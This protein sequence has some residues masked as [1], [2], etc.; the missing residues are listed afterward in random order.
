MIKAL[1]NLSL[2]SITMV[3]VVVALALN[4][5]S[6]QAQYCTPPHTS[7]TPC[8]SD[9]VFATI[10]NS[11]GAACAVPSYTNY[12]T[13]A[14]TAV[15]TKGLT[16]NM[17]VV[18]T[19]ASNNKISVWIDYNQNQ[20]Y[21]ASEWTRVYDVGQSG[22]VNITIPQTALSG[23]TGMRI[24][25]RLAS[26]PNEAI[27][28]CTSF[29]G[30][31]SE[32]Y[33]VTIID[34]SPCVAPP[35]AG[36]TIASSTFICPS[37][38]FNLSM[39]GNAFGTGMTY[40]WQSSTDSLVWTDMTGFT[41][42][43]AT[44]QITSTPVF[45]RCEL[46]CNTVKSA[47]TPV[48]VRPRSLL[49]GGTYT[50]NATL[51][52][53]STNFNSFAEFNAAI[54]CGITGP[55][56]L[57]V[58]PG[59][60]VGTLSLVNL[61][62]T[63]SVNTVTINGK[64]ATLIDTLKTGKPDFI[65]QIRG[66]NYVTIDSLTIEAHSSS[67]K[68]FVVSMGNA[69]YNT[70][71]NC[72][73]RGNQTDASSTTIGGIILSGTT[74]SATTATTG[75][76]NTFENNDISGGYYGMMLYGTTT[77][78][79]MKGNVIKNNTIRDYAYYGMYLF[80]GDSTQIIRN[81]IH[82]KNRTAVATITYSI[83]SGGAAQRYLIKGNK[84]H[85]V[86]QAGSSATFY[87][88]FCT[89]N[90]A[91][92]STQ[93]IVANNA[94]YNINTTGSQYCIYNTGSDH[95]KYFYNTVL[96]DN[97]SATAGLCYGFYQLTLATGIE[98]KNNIFSISKGGSGAKYCM[99]FGT[100]TTI[101]NTNYNDLYV[102]TSV[103]GTGVKNI[104]YHSAARVTLADWQ[105]YSSSVY[106]QNS[107]NV[108]PSISGL[109]FDDVKPNAAALNDAGVALTDIVDDINGTLRSGT[110]PDIGAVEF[111]PANDDAGVFSLVSPKGVCPG[112][113]MVSVRVKNY[114]ISTLSSVNVN[115]SVN[116]VN[117]TPYSYIGLVNSGADTLLSIGTF[118]VVANTP[119]NLKIWTS[120]PNSAVDANAV[121]DTIT[122]NGLRTG[123]IG[124]VTVGGSGADFADLQALST[125]LSANGICGTTTVNVNA[126]AGPYTTGISLQNVTGLSSS[127]TLTI[128]GNGAVINTLTHGIVLNKASYVT[129]DSFNVNLNGTS[130]FGIH[131]ME[132]DYNT[133]RKNTV[134]ITQDKTASTFSAMAMSG[135]TT[136][137]L[138]AG[139]FR[140]NTIENNVFNGGYYVLTVYGNSAD[141][142]SAV[143]NVVRNNKI[144]N[145]Y[146]YSI[147]SLGT[148]SL[149]VE[150]NDINRATRTLNI[151][152]F[153]GSFF[154]TGTRNL[155]YRN[156]KIHSPFPAG[157]TGTSISY[158]MY[159]SADATVGTENI[160]YNN[161]GYNI[162][163]SG[164][165][166]GLYTAGSDGSWYH[167]NTIDIGGTGAGT[168]YAVYQTTAA[169][170]VQFINNSLNINRI[171]GTGTRILL[172]LATNT[173]TV[174]SNYNHLNGNTGVVYGQWGTTQGATLA[175]WKTI[176]SSAFDQNSIDG[177]PTFNGIK[178]VIPKVGS[179][180]V[181][182]GTPLTTVTTDLLGVT[183]NSSTPTIG[184]YENA[185]DFSGPSITFTPVLNTLST[186]NYT[187]TNF[188]NIVDLTG[189]DTTAAN[190]PRLYYKLSTNIDTYND[191][192]SATDGWKY[193]SA[194]NTSSPFSFVIDY[195][196]LNA[197]L[198]VG[199][200]VQYFVVAQDVSGAA[201]VN[202]PLQ[203][204]DDPTNVNLTAG[205]FPILG[206]SPNSYRIA[207]TI[208]GTFVVGG[209]ETFK[210]LSGTASIFEH[211]NNN[212]LSG[213]VN[214]VVKTN[215]FETGA[216]ALN[217]FAETGAGGYKITIRPNADTL[218]TLSG[219]FV[220][221]LIKLNGTDRVIIDG[222]FNGSGKYL[223]FENNSAT[224]GT[225]G[226]QIISL[227]DNAGATKI[228]I[229]NSIILAGTAGNAIPIH[230]GGLTLPYS[231]GASNNNIKIVNNTI[232]RGSV[233][234]YSG[235]VAGFESDSLL[236]E[237][238]TIGSD[239]VGEQLRLYGMALEIQKNAKVH[240]NLIKNINNTAAQQAWGIA[241]YDGFLN[242]QI[243]NNKIERV[244]SGSGAFGGRGIE[245]ISN[246][247]NDN[248]L[249]AN[250]FIG[251]MAGGG[252]SNL[253]STANVGISIVATGGVKLYYNSVSLSGTS[254]I[255]TGAIPP[256]SAAL[257][258]G[259][260]AR[261]LDIRNNSFYNTLTNISDT[262]YAYAFYSEVGD[263]AFS[264]FNYNNYYASGTQGK[265]GFLTTDL[266]SLA[267][268]VTATS[269]N[270]N[271]INFNPNY[272][273]ATD[274]HAQGVSLYQKATPIAGITTDID[275]ETRS[276]TLPCIGA[277][278][279][280]PPPSEI[281]LVDILYPKG[282]V[283]CGIAND[284]IVI[285]VQNLGTATQTS[286]NVGAIISGAVNTTLNSTKTISLAPNTKDTITISG[287][288]SSTGTG[289]LSIKAYAKVTGDGESLNDTLTT[290]TT[291][292]AI[293]ANPTLSIVSP[294]CSGGPAMVFANSPAS[295]SWFANATGGP[296]IS[297]NDTL[298]T[299]PI[300]SATT[301]YAEATTSTVQNYLGGLPAQ[302]AGTS[303]AGT[304]NFGIVFDVL[305]PVTLQKVTVYP[306]AGVAG[307]AGTVTIDV[308][309]SAN[310]VLHTATV[311]VIGNPSTAAG[312]SPQEVTLNFNLVPGTNYKIRP[313]TRSAGITGLLF[314]PSATAPGGNYG[315]P[316][317]VP[318]VISITTSTLTA[319]PTNTARND[320]YYYFY[321]WKLSEGQAGCP[322]A[323]MPIT[324]V[325]TSGPAGSGVAQS[326]PFTGVFN[327]GT[328]VNADAACVSDT[329]TYSL[330]V[331]T[332][333]NLAGLGTTWNILNPVVK[334]L[335]GATPVGAIT[336]NGLSLQ[337]VAAAGDVDS[338]LMFTARVR[339]LSTGCDTIITRYLKVFGTPSVNLGN[340]QSICDGSVLTLDAGQASTYL[341]STGATTQT[342]QVSSTGIYSVVITNAAG[343]DATDAIV[344]NTTPSPSVN[345]GADVSSC[346]GTAV[347]LDAGNTGASYLWNTGATTQTIQAS[348]SG[349]YTVT[350][351]IGNCID[352]DTIQVS[353]NALPVVSLG[354]DADICTSDTITL[355]AG[356]TGSTYLWSTGATTQTIRV[357]NAGTYSVT[358]TNANTCVN[359][360]EIV[361]TNKAVPVSTFAVT[362]STGQSVT[363]LA[364]TT[365]GLQYAWNFG[366]PTSPANT[367][368]LA[369]PTH[370]FTAPGTYT[371][372]L[373]VTNVATGC[374]ATTTET[375]VVTGLGNDFAEVFKLGAAP[376]PFAGRT[377]ISYVLPENANNVTIEVYDM[378]G[379][380]V[381]S[382]L[383]DEYQAA[384]TYT[385][386]YKNEDLQTSSGVYMVRLTVDGN[387]AYSR[388]IDIAKK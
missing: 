364:T 229:K 265:L 338:T 281:E 44:A 259:A 267:N 42:I 374:R 173:S 123:L 54:N 293:P 2:K 76:Y 301:F 20:V 92:L 222:S 142:T 311:N 162:S 251:N 238:N 137:A 104:A 217:A 245:I 342:I 247:A 165:V 67:T 88:I 174:T 120:N 285:V 167:N 327:A 5:T 235:S 133:I 144:L 191:N 367:S 205:N 175:D 40:Q 250:N 230:I 278:E 359:T 202:A 9:V 243:T 37:T 56:V 347:T 140:Y 32:D 31:E 208:S 271:S 6:V 99:Y 356:N 8:I 147:Y 139:R 157:F 264:Q 355:D 298:T 365:S 282:N 345:L 372:T 207:N 341:W 295:I 177:N 350:V 183:R 155:R 105:A 82:R 353:F 150:N 13:S 121:N 113:A 59:T 317:V 237:G 354:L 151:T 214:I 39:Q 84:I 337:Y 321:N 90:D 61:S 385:Y 79:N 46:T 382:I 288:N 97:P 71:K 313:G 180:L 57:N 148:D 10:N 256:I 388:I 370:V 219:S 158:L 126:S 1:L 269:S 286:V 135:S 134:L 170:N 132:G 160:F 381:A 164:T 130:G 33:T 66:T 300:T 294:A 204:T 297:T 49:S 181:A 70:I 225:A 361:V 242:G 75:S 62:G 357:S 206:S 68:G 198:S 249:V 116:G 190:R 185:G 335:G 363:F 257:H 161:A 386:D 178:N 379:R 274:L 315:Y 200:I 199:S 324:V 299:G 124:T 279:F 351:S 152:T 273:S 14:F 387:V 340:D 111:T 122:L 368:Q 276:T 91:T 246:K 72:I 101:P 53:S 239:V 310:V 322:S 50:V 34:A 304:T 233:G 112:P 296:V 358:V 138:T 60:Y 309:N 255:T 47:S 110:T 228:E 216:H 252:S 268:I 329:L 65:L 24:R 166:Y 95:W 302:L 270:F 305:K 119:Y 334:T 254:S 280:L 141:L 227:G 349:V 218:R 232:M 51:P 221:G 182:A 128:N 48:K 41:S 291:I 248:I 319:A 371:V 343:C 184:A 215:L 159:I 306:V 179:P 102:N 114:G 115:W 193:V 289:A 220:G 275:A 212:I 58:T 169:T 369:N 154:S 43:V 78:A 143:G 384:G 312:A 187:L 4:S 96:I 331:P 28:A 380:K 100:A 18:S 348:A 172:N 194:T 109:A 195:S 224:S 258:V 106:D 261:L 45:Y 292:Y 118:N 241:V 210:S 352:I 19:G 260:G 35:T 146:F 262:S 344:V 277:D 330:T 176:N 64:G 360:D 149:I 197:S 272:N 377:L 145:A 125:F 373:S 328:L 236:I 333:F 63:S 203:L 163:G 85:D 29:G 30:G 136:S 316:M 213:D 287:Y 188:A 266:L 36:T 192:T 77:I 308:I 362:T 171:S 26:S 323:R 290:T 209:A 168:I 107:V 231:P 89:A 284:S 25:S 94:I 86:F 93:N 234:I 108:E 244:S 189:V 376:N 87:G 81:N 283:L 201:S 7:A 3:L 27:D 21:D 98:L 15:L 23:N 16:Y 22:N 11:S 52:N 211:I 17:S 74:N 129:I 378:I 325:P 253:S 12:P 336:M 73:I 307:T 131:I 320:L 186:S 346:V 339:N 332:G 69:S 383:T 156:N 117:Q 103:A 314:E 375:V 226:I 38:T 153:Y 127:S 240:N 83:Y 303:G 366:D 55:I 326:T 196:K 318:G 80:G 223:R 263:T